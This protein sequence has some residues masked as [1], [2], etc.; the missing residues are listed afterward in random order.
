MYILLKPSA[1]AAYGQSQQLSNSPSTVLITSSSNSLM[2]ASVKS[3]PQP[4][5]GAI[6]SKA[7]YQSTAHPSPQVRVE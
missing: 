2:S 3:S 6:G 1:A 5:L 7:S 4:P